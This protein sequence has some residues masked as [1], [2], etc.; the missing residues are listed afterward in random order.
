MPQ[1]ISLTEGTI[2]ENKV[3]ILMGSI[4]RFNEETF[5]KR[6]SKLDKFYYSP[7][8]GILEN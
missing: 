3:H 8:Y 1:N 2:Y 6:D 4:P 5:S 7:G